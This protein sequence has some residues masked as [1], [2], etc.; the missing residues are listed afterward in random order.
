[1]PRIRPISAWTWACVNGP[2]AF[3]G[4]STLARLTGGSPG[5]AFEGAAGAGVVRLLFERGHVLVEGHPK[6][7]HGAVIGHASA[8]QRHP[9]LGGLDSRVPLPELGGQLFELRKSRLRLEELALVVAQLGLQLGDP[10]RLS[11]ESVLKD[12][13]RDEAVPDVLAS[14]SSN[15][16]K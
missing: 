9:V 16:A 6:E 15:G 12:V 3:A 10:G 1:M 7:A 4:V 2:P 13:L 14:S 11:L 8:G 5:A